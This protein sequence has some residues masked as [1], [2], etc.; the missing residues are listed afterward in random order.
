VQHASQ[1]AVVT[2]TG[3][4]PMGIAWKL[5][6]PMPAALLETFAALLVA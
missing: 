4:R 6:T 5:E 1:P 3:E 2:H